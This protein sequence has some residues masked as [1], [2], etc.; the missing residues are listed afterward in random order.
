[1]S[2]RGRRRGLA[3]VATALR[4]HTGTREVRF[5]LDTQPR[6]FLIRPPPSGAPKLIRMGY[7]GGNAGEQG[8][9]NFLNEKLTPAHGVVDYAAQALYYNDGLGGGIDTHWLYPESLTVAP[10]GCDDY[11]DF[12]YQAAL[13]ADA[14]QRYPGVPITLVGYSSGSKLTMSWLHNEGISDDVA[15]IA[16]VKY[17]PLEEWLTGT[18]ER[19]DY[20]AAPPPVFLW[21]SSGDIVAPQ[22]APNITF[23]RTIDVWEQTNAAGVVPTTLTE[24]PGGATYDVSYYAGNNLRVVWEG[25][26]HAWNP[27]DKT[28][29][30]FNEYC[31]DL[32]GINLEG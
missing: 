23:S 10:S 28:D 2:R 15:A 1:M 32:L 11:T 24:G 13:I 31:E 30:E 18:P 16:L 27:N 9:E 3:G 25:G 4:R 19:F 7:H 29:E 6:R 8:S 26:T 14:L 22:T 5:T 12:R 21:L 17:T 20:A